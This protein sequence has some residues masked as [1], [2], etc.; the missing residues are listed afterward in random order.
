MLST[1]RILLDSRKQEIETKK[2]ISFLQETKL[3]FQQLANMIMII[4]PLQLE[5]GMRTEDAIKKL[6]EI[7]FQIKSTYK[8]ANEIISKHKK[9]SRI[10]RKIDWTNQEASLT[11]HYTMMISLITNAHKKFT[12]N[13]I[14]PSLNELRPP[15]NNKWLNEK[16]HLI[17]YVNF[18]RLNLLDFPEQT[19]ETI[20]QLT[21]EWR[22]LLKKFHPDLNIG[23]EDEANSITTELNR[24]YVKAK[25]QINNPD[26]LL[27]DFC[28]TPYKQKNLTTATF[29]KNSSFS[30]DEEMT[31]LKETQRKNAETICLLQVKQQELQREFNAQRNAIA[32]IQQEIAHSNKKNC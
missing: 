28:L 5:N 25:K 7:L 24:L 19:P 26:K 15:L 22:R 30:T 29:T 9:W 8:D 16:A 27:P 31:A 3:N 12:T 18:S 10:N 17:Q 20:K 1:W 23:Q 11:K 2:V 4:I 13:V 6:N 21:N 14:S 32:Q